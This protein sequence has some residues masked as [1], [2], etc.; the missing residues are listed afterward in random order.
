MIGSLLTGCGEAEV[1]KVSSDNTE[2]SAEKKDTVKEEKKSEFKLGE[3]VSVDGMEIT[4][5]K[6]TWGTPLQGVP[7]SKGKILRIEG[8]AKN[9]AAENGFI[10]NT[11]FQVYANDTA[12]E[13]YFGNDDANMLAG[14]LKKGKS[15]PIVLE[16][17]VPEANSYEVF[18]EPSF[19]LKENS[20]VK[21]IVSKGEIK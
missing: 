10:D 15:A 14:E 3:T 6:V 16:Y 1:K 21:W 19:T 7:A 9:N 12:T 13:N 8:T 18:Y 20:E 5:T 11:E 2:K 4:L 17:D